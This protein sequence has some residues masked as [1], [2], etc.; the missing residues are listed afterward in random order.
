MLKKIICILL[1]LVIILINSVYATELLTDITTAGS[2]VANVTSQRNTTSN[3]S[4]SNTSNNST[5]LNI[6]NN[7]NN[8]LETNINEINPPENIS[9]PISESTLTT[10]SAESNF[11]DSGSLSITNIINIVLISIGLVLV[12][13]GIAII[14]KLK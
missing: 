11:E 14:I 1:F 2:S 4:T 3:S 6:T 9:T 5:N 7:L 8:N 12:L 10:T 13:L